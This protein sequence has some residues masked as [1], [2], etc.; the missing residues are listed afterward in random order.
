VRTEEQAMRA[1][2]LAVRV[3]GLPLSARATGQ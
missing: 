2:K 1:A 3:A